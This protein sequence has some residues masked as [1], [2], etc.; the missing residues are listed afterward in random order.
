MAKFGKMNAIVSSVG[1]DNSQFNMTDHYGTQ[2]V[3]ANDAKNADE[4]QQVRTTLF[5]L[6]LDKLI[7]S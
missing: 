4:V 1:N 6:I 5:F 2:L 3:S 7:G